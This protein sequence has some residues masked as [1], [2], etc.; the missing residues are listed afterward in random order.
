[1]WLSVDVEFAAAG[2]ELSYS[3]VWC[4]DLFEYTCLHIAEIQGKLQLRS[5][6]KFLHVFLF[7]IILIMA[8][9]SGVAISCPQQMKSRA[10]LWNTA[11]P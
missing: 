9:I 7:N 2:S 11:V 1:M 8:V 6:S 3:R 4:F 5:S 10:M